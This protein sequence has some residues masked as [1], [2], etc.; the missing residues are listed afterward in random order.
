MKY[1]CIIKPNGTEKNPTYKYVRLQ[2]TSKV[3]NKIETTRNETKQNLPKRNKTKLNQ[4]KT[5]RNETK[6]NSHVKNMW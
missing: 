5:N 1:A 6:R 2:G 3:Q 4:N